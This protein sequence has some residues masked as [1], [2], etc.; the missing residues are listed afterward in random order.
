MTTELLFIAV[1]SIAFYCPYMHCTHTHANIKSTIFLKR[2]STINWARHFYFY[3]CHLVLCIYQHVR[4]FYFVGVVFNLNANSILTTKI[5][6]TGECSSYN[7]PNFK[8]LQTEKRSF[9][10]MSNTIVCKLQCGQTIMFAIGCDFVCLLLFAPCLSVCLC[11]CVCLCVFVGWLAC[12]EACVCVYT[13]THTHA[14]FVS[15]CECAAACV[16]VCTLLKYPC[17]HDGKFWLRITVCS[18]LLAATAT[19]HH[20]SATWKL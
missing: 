5:R 4:L 14:L 12:G 6:L 16:F 17:Y 11:V 19:P 3:A 13:H 15:V 1:L 7:R 8:T 18:R 9:F 20:T 2:R 10:L